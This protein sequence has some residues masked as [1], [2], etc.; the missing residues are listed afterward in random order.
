ML[1]IWPSYHFFRKSLD[2][3][4]STFTYKTNWFAWFW[5]AWGSTCLNHHKKMHAVF[6][7]KSYAKLMRNTILSENVE[8]S[9][10]PLK[11]NWNLQKM[12][13]HGS[14]IRRHPKTPN[15]GPIKSLQ[16][17]YKF[18]VGCFFSY[19]KQLCACSVPTFRAR[20]NTCFFWKWCKHQS[21]GKRT[22]LRLKIFDF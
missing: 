20:A 7:G 16:K 2:L 14:Q 4:Y 6:D 9:T 8:N 15:S 3:V 11:L 21:L 22:Y 1:L 18:T 10:F 19:A 5:A 13:V 17:W 12:M